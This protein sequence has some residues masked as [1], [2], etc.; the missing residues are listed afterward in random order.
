MYIYWH[1]K[2]KNKR[3]SSDTKTE[4]QLERSIT[5]IGKRKKKIT[6]GREL[7]ES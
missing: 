2:D 3:Y 4:V 6:G 7:A 1:I 5:T